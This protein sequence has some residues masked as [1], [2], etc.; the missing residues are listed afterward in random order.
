MERIYKYENCTVIVHIPDD[1]CFQERLCKASE[2]FM[3]KVIGG[4]SR[5]GNGNTS[6]NF[7]EK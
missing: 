5:H 1:D 2:N 7:R 3:K 4:G 6:K